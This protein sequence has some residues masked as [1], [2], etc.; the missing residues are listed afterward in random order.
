MPEGK[1]AEE[2]ATEKAQEWCDKNKDEGWK[3]TGKT[4]LEKEGEEEIS[5][6]E[7]ER[8]IK[9]TVPSKP[10]NGGMP[11]SAPIKEETKTESTKDET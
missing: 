8:T 1:T 6:F 11:I 5:F 4:K 9:A 3:Y 10:D 7:V 2:V